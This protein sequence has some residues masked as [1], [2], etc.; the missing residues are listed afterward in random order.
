MTTGNIVTGG[1]IRITG[2]ELVFRDDDN[3][4]GNGGA[5]IQRTLDLSGASA[6]TIS[7]D[8]DENSFDAGEI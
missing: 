2:S 6:V 8:Y 5:Q 7:Y 4:A 3:D 1:Q